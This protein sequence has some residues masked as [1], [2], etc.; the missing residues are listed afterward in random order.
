[1]KITDGSYELQSGAD[2]RTLR[3]DGISGEGSGRL[4]NRSVRMELRSITGSFKGVPVTGKGVLRLA[5]EGVAGELD[6][7]DDAAKE[8]ELRDALRAARIT[9]RKSPAMSELY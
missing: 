9:L 4:Q 8:P 5:H 2:D 6:V 1:V 7:N 3:I